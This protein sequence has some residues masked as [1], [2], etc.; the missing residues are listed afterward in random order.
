MGADLVEGYPNS[1][2]CFYNRLFLIHR[3]VGDKGGFFFFPAHTDMYRLP[4]AIIT[5]TLYFPAPL[6]I[7]SLL[8]FAKALG[9]TPR[10]PRLS[11]YRCCST[12]HPPPVTTLKWMFPRPP[13]PRGAG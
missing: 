1:I 10:K 5:G 8:Q 2:A 7:L 3:L 6:L 12:R 4:F 13:P 11:S 9:V